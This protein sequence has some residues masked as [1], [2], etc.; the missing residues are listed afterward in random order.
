MSSHRN[1]RVAEAIR[2]VIANAILFDVND[3]RV[4]N[5]TVLAVEVSEDIRYAKVFVTVT[6]DNRDEKRVIHGLQSARGFLQSKVAARLQTRVTPELKFEID[7]SS[8]RTGELL[9]LIEAAVGDVQA[10]SD[11]A[12]DEADPDDSTKLSDDNDD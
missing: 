8:K 12:I 3:P 11:V 7:N 2:E 4:R 5:V 1:L 6:G 9:K 10:P